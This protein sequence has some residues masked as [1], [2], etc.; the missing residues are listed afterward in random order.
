[1]TK[2][3]IVCCWDH[4]IIKIFK[5]SKMPKKISEINSVSEN[6]NSKF[7]KKLGNQQWKHDYLE[8]IAKKL[9]AK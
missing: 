1:M 8:L 2:E 5:I 4:Q 3:A 6:A 9:K 7:R